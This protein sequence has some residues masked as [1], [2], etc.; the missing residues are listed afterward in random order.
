MRSA[1]LRA[2]IASGVMLSAAPLAGA[3]NHT[4]TESPVP[5]AAQAATATAAPPPVA[6]YDVGLTLGNELAHNGVPAVMDFDALLRGLT[7][8]T[9]G[10]LATREQQ[11]QGIRFVRAAHD[12][13]VEQNHAAAREFLKKNAQQAGVRAMP[14]GLQ[15]RVLASGAPSGQP[16]GPKDKVTIRYRAS[17]ADG[18]EF[19]RSEQHGR[20]AEFERDAVAPGFR[21]A[22]SVMKPGDHW[23]LFIPPE[24]G[25]DARTPPG[26]PPGA[27]LVYDI[28]L[29]RVDA[30]AAAAPAGK[31]AAP[32]AAPNAPR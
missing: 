1:G 4:G 32:V 9:H 25:Y 18:T 22:L 17:L 8:G 31:V 6:S 19:D 23:E 20:P 15:Y 27:L 21:E 12:A 16:A 29:L 11:E 3:D 28:E 7:D 24:L 2:L 30:A 14:S 26:V 13:L 10:K 5:A